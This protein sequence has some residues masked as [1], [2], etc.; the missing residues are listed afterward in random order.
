MGTYPAAPAALQDADLERFRRQGYLAFEGVLSPAEVTEACDALGRLIQSMWQAAASGSP[1]VTVSPPSSDIRENYRGVEMERTS[2]AHV[3]FQ[4]GV[5]PFALTL[6]E[7]EMKVRKVYSFRR[8]TPELA[9]LAAHPRVLAIV[10]ALVGS[11]ALLFQEMA[12]IKPPHIG[13]EKPWHQDDA[14]FSYTP[15]DQ[16]V[17]VWLALDPAGRENGCMHVLAGHHTR[18]GYRHYHSSLD[19]EI[20]PGRIRPEEA[21]PIEL[22]PGGAL[23]FSGMLPHQTPTNRSALRR[24]AL[25]FHYR[26]AST[27]KVSPEEY[28]RVFAEADGTPASCRAAAP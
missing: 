25:Q 1:E 14:Y 26:G 3:D 28:D 2:G 12:L 23:F 8:D 11:G 20:L 17:G 13:S 27:R 4:S 10:E 15:L 6:D 7:A 19:C 18:G 5:D 21:T 9:R 22:G 24:R 16:V